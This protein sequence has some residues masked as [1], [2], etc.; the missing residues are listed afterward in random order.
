VVEQDGLLTPTKGEFNMEDRCYM[1][2]T[3]RRQDKERFEAVGF[4]LDFE[5][6]PESLVIEMVDEEANYAHSSEMP[7]DIPYYGF[8]G[9]G[10]N[11]GDGKIA[12]DGKKC[13][14]VETGHG[15]GFVIGWDFH[16][17]QP[18]GKCI[19]NI[20]HFIVIQQRAEKIIKALRQSEPHEHVFS[21]T[22]NLC[23][24]C[25]INADDD[26]V[27]NQSCTA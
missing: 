1:S 24:H 7:T 17:W 8:N 20:R 15:G 12:C 16:T 10:S 14:E 26:A 13:A 5:S 3:C 18:T 6:S 4:H 27:E 2:V 23:H 9:A 21:P 19:K 22:T 25:G 11:Y